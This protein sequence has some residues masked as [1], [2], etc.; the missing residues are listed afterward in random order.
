MS[1]KRIFYLLLQHF[2]AGRRAPRIL[3]DIN[4]YERDAKGRRAAISAR[5]L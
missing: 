4:R 2:S 3:E 1:K 5:N